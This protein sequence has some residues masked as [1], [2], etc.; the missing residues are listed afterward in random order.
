MLIN[1]CG[2]IELQNCIFNGLSFRACL[3]S[4][5]W[6]FWELLNCVHG[7]FC[8]WD[9]PGKDTGVG[10]HFLLQGI[11]LIQGSSFMSPASPSLAGRFVT[12]GSSGRS[13]LRCKL[14]KKKLRRNEKIRNQSNRMY[15]VSFLKKTSSK[16]KIVLSLSKF[17][18]C[19]IDN[20]ICIYVCVCVCVIGEAC[21]ETGRES[22]SRVDIKMKVQTTLDKE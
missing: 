21:N 5:V 17:A 3:L 22:L 7:F 15:F 6:L 10:C 14:C 20:V 13:R 8:P 4:H 11:S 12:T 18:Y 1:F 19:T 9:F 16:L 2:P